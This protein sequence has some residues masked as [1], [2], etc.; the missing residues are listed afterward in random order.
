MSM[1]YILAM[2][3]KSQIEQENFSFFIKYWEALLDNTWMLRK[4][5]INY[6]FA[7]LISFAGNI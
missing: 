1:E 4:K 5:E 6:L 7:T 2:T 3:L